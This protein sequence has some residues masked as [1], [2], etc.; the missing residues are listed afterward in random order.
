[1]HRAHLTGPA[2]AA[3]AALAACAPAADR[4][5]FVAVDLIASPAGPGSAEPNLAVDATGQV[6]LTWLERTG[7][8]TWALRH[9]RRDLDHWSAPST[10]VE[11]DDLFVNWADFPSVFVA[12]SGQITAH[13]LQRSSGG[14]YS[15][16]VVIRQSSDGGASWSEPRTLN[17]DGRPVEHGFVS[18]V[19]A[20]GDSVEAFWLDGRATGGYHEGGAMQLANSRIAADGGASPNVMLDTRICDCCQTS[21]AM[22][23]RG[24][25]VVYR[26][27]S[28]DEIRDIAIVR[29]VAGRWT[30]PARVHAD[31]WHIDGCPVN[32]PSV[33]ADGEL[34]AVAWF[35]G[36]RDTARVRLAFSS[37]AGAT[38]GPAIQ[39]DE[40]N[41]V[42]R[43]DVELDDDGRAIVS[44]LE[45]TA[46]E[47]AAVLVRAVTPAGIRSPVAPVATSSAARAAGFPRMAR[48]GSDIVF[49]WTQPGDTSRV[50]LAEGRLTIARQ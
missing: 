1:M 26:D 37:D 12:P 42:G 30:E 32:G 15:Y 2:L 28:P 50:F 11:R 35:T 41:P 20:E 44:W 27:R 10:I 43:V 8:S 39:V 24:P 25:V 21:A 46:G 14:R 29:R 5:A 47:E 18:F 6:H 31:E 22:T 34:V 16:D 9:A 36:A 49:A 17:T 33:A 38:F 13:W 19:G 48:H 3:L 45:R 23:S 4:P 7:E 40:G